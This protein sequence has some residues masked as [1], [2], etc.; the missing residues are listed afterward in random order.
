MLPEGAL[1][2]RLKALF[3]SDVAITLENCPF[4][5]SLSRPADEVFVSVVVSLSVL[6]LLPSD[7]IAT[8]F[9]SGS[10]GVIF[11]QPPRSRRGGTLA[12]C[13]AQEEREG[14]SRRG[15]EEEAHAGEVHRRGEGQKAE[16]GAVGRRVGILVAFAPGFSARKSPSDPVSC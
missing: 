13:S 6:S 7:H 2:E 9:C 14:A 15:V 5:F 1:R 11:L 8:I 10:L 4:P 12:R 3:A 16:E